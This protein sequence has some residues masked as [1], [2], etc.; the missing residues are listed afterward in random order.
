MTGDKEKYLDPVQTLGSD[1]MEQAS[2]Y[3]FSYYWP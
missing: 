1:S 3:F 2:L